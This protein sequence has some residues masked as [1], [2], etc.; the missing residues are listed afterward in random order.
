VRRH[1]QQKPAQQV[2]GT[3]GGA[4]RLS[5]HVAPA[6]KLSVRVRV[7]GGRV[8]GVSVR[9]RV[10]GGRV[11]GRNNGLTLYHR[12]RP[13][14]RHPPAQRLSGSF[15]TTHMQPSKPNPAFPTTISKRLEHSRPRRNG[16][17]AFYSLAQDTGA[18]RS[19]ETATP[20]DPTVGLCL[21]PYGGLWGGGC[22]PRR[23]APQGQP[24]L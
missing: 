2:C 12:G 17:A 23:R 11:G 6:Q 24:L 1:F 16:S 20:Y 9:V 15:F 8:G 3:T 18:P 10:H 21:G 19:Y 4:R 5:L 13:P 7:H 14:A 22:F